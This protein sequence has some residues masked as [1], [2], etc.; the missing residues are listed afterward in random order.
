VKEDPSTYSGGSITVAD[1]RGTPWKGEV[2]AP[3]G[4]RVLRFEFTQNPAEDLGDRAHAYFLVVFPRDGHDGAPLTAIHPGGGNSPEQQMVK[5]FAYAQGIRLKKRQPKR[6]LK[7]VCPYSRSDSFALYYRTKEKFMRPI[8]EWTV[9]RFGV[10]PERVYLAGC[11]VGGRE[12]LVQGWSNGDLFAAIQ[13]GCPFVWAEPFVSRTG[14]PEERPAPDASA[15]EKGEY[16]SVV[17]ARDLANTPPVFL[18]ARWGPS[19]RL[20][21]QWMQDGRH[22]AVMTYGE[23]VS[24]YDDYHPAFLAF[25]WW[26][27]RRNEAYPVFTNASTDGRRPNDSDKGRGDDKKDLW[28]VNAYF[29]WRNVEDARDRFAI[30]LRLVTKDEMVEAAR[31]AGHAPGKGKGPITLF[32][33]PKESTADVTLRRLQEF[34]VAAGRT[35]RWW[36]A[37]GGG[38]VASGE[39]TADALGLLTVPRVTVTPAP[40]RLVVERGR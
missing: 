9:K 11:S 2:P 40:T 17:T 21:S 32:E 27:I 20:L 14:L 18:Y 34:R 33:P 5:A 28:Q 6:A 29:R 22:L 36:L 31:V 39:A 7:Y 8:V 12:T 4:R 26:E 13:P 23:H 3:D 38:T 24:W 37:R 19:I 10:D 1:P 15:K 16:V 35:Y 30:E 25:P